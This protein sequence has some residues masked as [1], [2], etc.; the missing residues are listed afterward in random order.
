MKR[1][2][3]NLITV[4]FFAL[5]FTACK[6]DKKE[7]NTGDMKEVAETPAIA[8]D[9]DVNTEESVIEWKGSKP[10]KTHNGTI[11]LAS[12]SLS[13]VDGKVEAGK[14]SIDMN[15]ITD[16]D[17][18]GKGKENLENHLK[19]T[20]EGKESDFFN[21]PKYPFSEFYLT[22]INTV[23][24]QTMVSGNLTI[25]DKTHNIEFPA[26]V[27]VGENDLTLKSESFTIDRTLWGVNFGSKTVFDNLGDKFIDN[28]I[29]LKVNLVAKKS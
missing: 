6:N 3:L 23:N 14:F 9:Y 11:K 22:G 27:T 2:I 29:E 15:S 4:S 16:L 13:V 26:A 8:I 21:V 25:K 20:V 17:L 19:G 28:D 12:G 18:E 10:L 24:G 7:A 1:I 5:S